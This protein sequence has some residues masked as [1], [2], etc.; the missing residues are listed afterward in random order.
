MLIT[1]YNYSDDVATHPGYNNALL[2][3]IHKKCCAREI[4]GHL[5][6]KFLNWEIPAK[7]KGSPFRKICT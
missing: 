2:Y 3:A 6:W 1:S 4:F 5:D 7:A